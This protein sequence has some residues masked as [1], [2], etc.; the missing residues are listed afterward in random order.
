MADNGIDEDF[1]R[2]D[3]AYDQFSGDPTCKSNPNTGAI[4][5][6]PFYAI[7]FWPGDWAQKEDW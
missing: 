7:D 3:S 5:Q 4:K 6:G 1:G 2:G